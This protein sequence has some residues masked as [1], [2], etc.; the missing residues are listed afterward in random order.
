[1]IKDPEKRLD[2]K[3]ALEH[4]WIQQKVQSKFNTRLAEKAINNLQKFKVRRHHLNVNF[5]N[6][7]YL[8]RC[9]NFYLERVEAKAGNAD[10]HDEP[11]CDQ[12]TDAGAAQQFQPI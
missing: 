2:A 8:M 5:A 1:M 9:R 7:I 4:P 12:E 6:R 3:T 10:L 11:S